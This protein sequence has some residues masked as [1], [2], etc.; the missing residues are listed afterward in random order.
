MPSDS[1][2]CMDLTITSPL[3]TFSLVPVFNR[4]L[5]IEITTHTVDILW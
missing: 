3:I 1:D 4:S 5:Y 2:M